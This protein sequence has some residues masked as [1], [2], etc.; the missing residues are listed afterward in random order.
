MRI[1]YNWG[2][3]DRVK[4]SVL[5]PIYNVEKFLPECLDSLVNQTLKEIEI[6][7]INDGSTD[8]SS[9]IIKEYAEKD[10]RIKMIDKK[11]SGYGDSMNQGLKKATGEYVGIVE[12]DDFIDLNAFEKL[13]KIAKREKA[14]VIKANFYEYFTDKKKDV[15]KSEMFLPEDTGMLF[16]PSEHRHIFYQKPS[17]WSAIYRNA[18]LKKNKID[19]LPSPGASYQD[20]GFNFKVWASTDRAFLVDEAFLHYRQDN[21]NSSVKDSGKVYCVKDEYDEVERFL[22]EKGTLEKYGSTLATMR[23]SSYIWN[24]KRLARKQALE[25]A[26][27]VKEDYVRLEKEGFLDANKLD[28]V[29]KNNAKMIVT[30]HPY[31]YVNVRPLHEAKNKTRA[32]LVKTVKVVFPGYKQRIQTINLVKE[33]KMTQRELEEK[34]D[35][36]EEKLENAEKK[37]G[38]K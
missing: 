11:N 20:A 35:E 17:I 22:K 24:M 19:F 7:C 15:A 18:F 3:S 37:N 34:I 28:K 23:L 5:V 38:K 12:S 1:W 21:P 8:K 36:L 32:V 4:V 2:M 14:D 30:K 16:D 29:G 27:V 33:M 26:K 25:F 9:K 31:L 10:K 13:Y 6:I